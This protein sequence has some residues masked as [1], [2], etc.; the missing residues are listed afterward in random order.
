MCATTCSRA[1][2]LGR[3]Q[4]FGLAKTR[5]TRTRSTPVMRSFAELYQATQTFSA[6]E[7]ALAADSELAPALQITVP[8]LKRC[9]RY[10]IS[11]RKCR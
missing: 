8:T 5:C 6:A 2:G 11:R 4:K 1:S 3:L 9:S 10:S 7:L